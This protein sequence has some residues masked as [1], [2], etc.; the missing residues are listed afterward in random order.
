MTAFTIGRCGTSRTS[1]TGIPGAIPSNTGI[2]W[3]RLSRRCKKTDPK[4]K[5]IYG[6]QADPSREFTQKALDTCKCASGIDVYAYHTYPG[7][8][9]NLN[10]ESMDYGAYLNE[11]PRALARSGYALSGDQARH[12]VLR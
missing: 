5:V 6:G 4:A 8:G 12:S 7:Y 3:L 9:Q 10:P 11:S 2:C 1:D